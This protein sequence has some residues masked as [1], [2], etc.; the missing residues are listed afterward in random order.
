M[1]ILRTHPYSF[2]KIAVLFALFA[3]IFCF[4]FVSDVFAA[5]SKRNNRPG[6]EE[7]SIATPTK[8]FTGRAP[9]PVPTGAV[10]SID[11][12]S[13][14][15]PI[16]IEGGHVLR[17]I[18]FGPNKKDLKNYK[19]KG[20]NNFINEQLNPSSINDDKANN[21]LPGIPK[22]EDNILDSDMIRRWY[23]RMIFT[24]RVLLEKMTL[25]WHEHFSTSQEKVQS[26]ALM[27]EHENNLR[28]Y[29]LGNFREFLIKMSQDQ[30]MLIW[31]DNNYNRGHL[32]DIPTDTGSKPNENYAREFL[33]LFS[34]GTTLLNI[35][36]TPILDGSG[37]PK[38]AY[39]EEDILH[40]SLAMSGWYTPWPRRFN[41][42]EFRPWIHN[43]DNK[44]LFATDPQ[45]GIV[46][47]GHALGDPNG[48]VETAAVVDAV[49]ASQTARGTVTQVASV[50]TPAA[51]QTS[52]LAA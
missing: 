31:L 46:I 18:G 12:T 51:S 15:E 17:R 44:T 2:A 5:E 29:A 10:R 1:G 7:P 48:E 52:Q 9:L 22:N 20:F 24:R 26:G 19:K 6:T 49:P 16:T 23:I 25:I 33:Q 30:A 32:Y 40:I 3:S 45:G 47:P 11:E 35:D 4:A 43:N 27:L 13:A 38:P 8:I 21:K 36:G 39:T 14:V 50:R 28:L 41:N 34:T 42:V 37:N